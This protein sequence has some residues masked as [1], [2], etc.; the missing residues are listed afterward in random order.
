MIKL[1]NRLKN[2]WYFAARNTEKTWQ[3]Y[4]DEEPDYSWLKKTVAALVIFGLVYGAQVSN[5][6]V[7]QEVTSVVRQILATQTDFVYYAART[8]D[9]INTYWPNSTDLSGIPVLKQMQSTISRPADPLRYMTKPV[10]G[11]VMKQYGW[12]GNATSTQ[13]ILHEGIEIAAP[14]GASVRAAA[15]GKVKIVSES[16]QFG[17][18]LILDHG[19]NIE[20]IY[21]H[22]TDILVKEGDEVSQ[23][24]VVARVGKVGTA[25]SVLYFELRENGKAIDPLSRI[26]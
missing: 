24:Q 10:D 3:S 19:K 18:L 14:A 15:T 25:V 11:Q 12:Q 2:R 23:G 1:W 4:Y 21:G 6:K 26:K 9:Y 16:V 13:D 22:L 5:T 20:T 8:I 17:K 7:G